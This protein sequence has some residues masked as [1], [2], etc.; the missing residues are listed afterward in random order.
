MLKGG[1]LKLEEGVLL[2]A[3]INEAFAKGI[4]TIFN[5]EVVSDYDFPYKENTFAS[6]YFYQDS[7]NNQPCSL[8]ETYIDFGS[9]APYKIIDSQTISIRNHSSGR[10]SCNWVMPAEKCPFIIEPS[11]A[12]ISPR[13]ITEF[14]V[15][16]KPSSEN[17]FYGHQLECYVYFKGHRNFRLVTEETFT[18]PWCL[19][20]IVTGYL[21]FDLG[22]H[23][24]PAKKL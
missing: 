1:I 8:V 17:S 9:C 12:D 21:I 15:S 19:L 2:F 10:M 13:S 11:I 20:A 23:F 22:I 18:P 24:L 16:F 3:D 7:L 6:K 5:L 14:K 4:I